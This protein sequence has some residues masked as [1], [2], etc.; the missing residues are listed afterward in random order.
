MFVRF[1]QPELLIPVVTLG[2]LSTSLHFVQFYCI[3]EKQQGFAKPRFIYQNLVYL[4]KLIFRNI[5]CFFSRPK[6]TIL[7]SAIQ[8]LKWEWSVK[9]EKYQ[10]PILEKMS[11]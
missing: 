4:G 11:M 5:S 7:Q 1:S 10:E 6:Q 2:N 9:E 3:I 8:F